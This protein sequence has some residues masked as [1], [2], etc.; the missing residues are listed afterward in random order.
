M[1]MTCWV[2]HLVCKGSIA[3]GVARV[4]EGLQLRAQGVKQAHYCVAWI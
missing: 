2:W 4:D 1:A 3:F